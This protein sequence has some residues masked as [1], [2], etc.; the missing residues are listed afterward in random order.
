V[1]SSVPSLTVTGLPSGG[2]PLVSQPI[3]LYDRRRRVGDHRPA[4]RRLDDQQAVRAKAIAIDRRR[5]LD[6]GLAG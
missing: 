3:V 1:P 2:V 4:D 5:V 6:A